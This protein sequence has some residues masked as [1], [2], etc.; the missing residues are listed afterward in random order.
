MRRAR[1]DL[2]DRSVHLER[3]LNERRSALGKD[4]VWL[5]RFAKPLDQAIGE[6]E[7]LLAGFDDA[8]GSCD[9]GWCFT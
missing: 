5:T 7:E 3:T 9:S 2:F 6:P 8:A 4:P 1:P